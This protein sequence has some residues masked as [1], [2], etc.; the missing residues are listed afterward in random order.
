MLPVF[1]L[2]WQL[3]AAPS[4]VGGLVPSDLAFQIANCAIG[5]AFA[6]YAAGALMAGTFLAIDRLGLSDG[7]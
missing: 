4:Y 2:T 5:G 7:R 1:V 6:G 3:L